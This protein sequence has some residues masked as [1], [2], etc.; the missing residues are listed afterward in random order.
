MNLS[1]RLAAR[2]LG[3]V[4]LDAPVA[5]DPAATVRDTIGAMSAAGATC[6]VI[7]SSDMPVGIF[8]D[9][10]ALQRVVGHTNVCAQPIT[11]AMT[12]SPQSLPL[13]STAHDALELMNARR[14][15][16]VLVA[17]ESGAV[18]GVLTDGG[19]VRMIDELLQDQEVHDEHDPGAQHGLMFVD[20]TGLTLAKPV[21]VHPDDTVATAIHHMRSRSIGSV[22][23]VDERSSL[24]G[25]FTERDVLRGVACAVEDLTEAKVGSFM[26]PDP[27]S[28]SP[29]A[30][31]AEGFHQM[32]THGFTHLP[33][34]AETGR[35]VGIASFRDLAEYLEVALTASG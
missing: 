35:A 8:T 11:T 29:R 19:I 30:M 33:L 23:V 34:V 16:H 32:A 22:L 21:V 14:L 7:V 10:D 12:D 15:R 17:A 27:V 1:A 31:I 5:V 26:T 4:D 3:D 9:R 28:V 18:I 6:A 25:I 2:R 20:F 13:G 24:I